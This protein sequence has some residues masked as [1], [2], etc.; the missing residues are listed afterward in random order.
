[1]LEK[2]KFLSFLFNQKIVIA[3]IVIV[4]IL[5]LATD[6]FLKKDNIINILY[7][8]TVEGIIAIGMT[9]IFISGELDL[10]VGSNMALAA[11]FAIMFLKFGLGI[12][13]FMGI[14]IGVVVGMVNGFIVTKLKINSIATTL[15]MMFILRGIVFWL[16]RSVTI[17]GTNK[18]FVVLSNGTL[19]SIPYPVYLFFFFLIIF[20]LILTKTFFGKNIF[21]IGG[22][23]TAS[24]YFGI[25]IDK[26]K[27]FAFLLI[28]FLTGISGVTLA[29]RINIASAR[30]GLDTP[31]NVIT[32]VA[33]GGTSLY[34]GEGGMLKTLQG[35]LLIG[36][37]S[38]ALILLKISPFY[39]DV[40]KGALLIMVLAL[41]SYYMSL[42]KY[43]FE[44]L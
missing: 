21:A 17:K 2:R 34:G 12:A 25:N 33:L 37:I 32:A 40:I 8:I 16:T 31:L 44:Q 27:F 24:L 6:T 20:G 4:I 13:I 22:N 14:L 35:I 42:S 3:L 9:Y 43:R 28:G 29:S 36:V 18:A 5:S 15:A 19:I 1:V 23:P 10:S 7:Q 39:H 11:T 26:T 38:N 41:D 30:L